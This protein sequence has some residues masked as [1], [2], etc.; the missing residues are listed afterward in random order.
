MNFKAA[1]KQWLVNDP[2]PAQLIPTIVTTS[3]HNDASNVH[4]IKGIGK[5]NVS[6]LIYVPLIA[7]NKSVYATA[8]VIMSL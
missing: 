3:H 8:I 1:L 5:L 4:D 2:R 6:N 7:L